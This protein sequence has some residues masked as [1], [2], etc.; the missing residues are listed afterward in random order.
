MLRRLTRPRR[1]AWRS[2]VAGVAA[3]CLATSGCADGTSVDSAGEAD[4]RTVTDPADLGR[5][6]VN[7]GTS[8]TGDVV[9]LVGHGGE[10]G[11]AQ[12]YLVASGSSDPQVLP[13]LPHPTWF[14]DSYSVASERWVLISAGT[15]P[16]VPIEED[17]GVVCG[18][19][20]STADLFAFDRADEQW[21]TVRDPDNQGNVAQPL[22]VAGDVAVLE[23]AVR[24]AEDRA[25]PRMATLDLSAENPTLERVD[26]R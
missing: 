11:P 16:E 7:V 24:D 21:L 8:L 13:D 23:I 25:Q 15:C 9:P 18:D 14:T 3:A 17:L 1:S 4:D 12:V 10:D 19:G 5:Q 20:E 22:N 26:E 2:A 6:R